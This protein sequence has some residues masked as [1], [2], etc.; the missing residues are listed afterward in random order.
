MVYNMAANMAAN[1]ENCIK[2]SIDSASIVITYLFTI[3]VCNF[4]FFN[5]KKEN[6]ISTENVSFKGLSANGGNRKAST[7]SQC[8]VFFFFKLYIFFNDCKF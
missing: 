2:Y 1:L 8:T 7:V 3:H 4:I 6:Y 5:A